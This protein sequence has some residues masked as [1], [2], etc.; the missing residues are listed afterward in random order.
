MKFWRG[1]NFT[2]ENTTKLSDQHLGFVRSFTNEFPI[3][4]EG[5]EGGA[6]PELSCRWLFMND[7]NFLEVLGNVWCNAAFA[8]IQEK[9]PST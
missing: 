7:Q 3:F 2:S 5:R 8:V 1:T 4:P 9:I 6:T